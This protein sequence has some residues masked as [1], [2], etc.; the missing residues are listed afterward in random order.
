MDPL[1]VSLSHGLMQLL[2]HKRSSEELDMCED[3]FAPLPH[4]EPLRSPA[5]ISFSLSICGLVNAGFSLPLLYT[6]IDY[7]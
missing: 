2:R 7:S 6:G 5:C 3:G 4:T 1:M